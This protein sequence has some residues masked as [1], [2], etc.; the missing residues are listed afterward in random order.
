MN[1]QTLQGTSHQWFSEFFSELPR[2]DPTDAFQAQQAE[3]GNG[4]RS[5]AD[6][7]L[8]LCEREAACHKVLLFGLRSASLR[9]SP[10]VMKMW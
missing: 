9:R 1:T 5:V 4:D 7:A 8:D 2:R 6:H 10:V 3:N